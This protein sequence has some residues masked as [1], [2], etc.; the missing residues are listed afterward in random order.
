MSGDAGEGVQ[1]FTLFASGGE[2][3]EEG[4]LSGDVMSDTGEAGSVCTGQLTLGC[5]AAGVGASCRPKHST[6]LA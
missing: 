6:T 2:E 3:V 5:E 1:C 4:E